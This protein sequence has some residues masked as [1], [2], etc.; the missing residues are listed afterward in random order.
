VLLI[1]IDRLN[2]KNPST[3]NHNTAGAR[4]DP[5][6]CLQASLT[7]ELWNQCINKEKTRKATGISVS[8]FAHPSAV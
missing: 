7:P 1:K 8:C 6:Y 4:F 5:G 2:E 3:D